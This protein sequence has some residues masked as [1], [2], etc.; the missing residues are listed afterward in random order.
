M[1]KLL[2]IFMY[3]GTVSIGGGLATIPFLVEEVVGRGFVSMDMLYTIIAVSE[4]TPGPLGINMATFI[5][6]NR[7]GMLGGILCSIALVLPSF[8]IIILITKA[9]AK[10]K[11]SAKIHALIKGLRVAVVGLIFVIIL[12]LISH[13]FIEEG[14]DYIGLVCA[15]IMVAL[16]KKYDRSPILYIVLGALVGLVLY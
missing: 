12:D 13:V 7:Y 5:G 16:I 2:M 15:A 11:N 8:V 6:F 9:Y 3:I 14:I 1:I 10:Y 4:S